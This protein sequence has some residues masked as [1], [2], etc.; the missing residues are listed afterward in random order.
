MTKPGDSMQERSKWGI[1]AD[2]TRK[3]LQRV[4]EANSWPPIEWTIDTAAAAVVGNVGTRE[5][6]DGLLEWITRLA[7]TGD[8]LHLAVRLDRRRSEDLMFTADINYW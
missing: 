4:A 7:D 6:W 2:L 1:G 8:V 3:G 5:D